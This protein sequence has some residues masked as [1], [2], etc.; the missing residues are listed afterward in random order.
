MLASMIRLSMEK[1]L[2]RLNPNLEKPEN[3]F[4]FGEIGREVFEKVGGKLKQEIKSI[5]DEL[6]GSGTELSN[7]THRTLLPSYHE[8]SPA[9]PTFLPYCRGFALCEINS[10][11]REF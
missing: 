5:N 10:S 2:H 8:P 4:A 11:G 3:R 6:Q 9:L 7:R 1:S